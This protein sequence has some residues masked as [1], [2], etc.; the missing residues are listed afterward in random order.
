VRPQAFR[1]H[2]I[3]A[4]LARRS[5]NLCRPI[6]RSWRRLKRYTGKCQFRASSD[7]RGRRARHPAVRG[8]RSRS[9]RCAP[10][11]IG[12]GCGEAEALHR[13][14]AIAIVQSDTVTSLPRRAQRKRSQQPP[15]SRR[16]SYERAKHGSQKWPVISAENH[17]STELGSLSSA[18]RRSVSCVHLRRPGRA[19]A[20]EYQHDRSMPARRPP[21]VD[22]GGAI[23]SSPAHRLRK[24]RSLRRRDSP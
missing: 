9:R 21:L 19:V 23:L 17:S 15:V 7:A 1:R 20:G 16:S 22:T 14:Q 5:A 4:R 6:G 8:L 13:L 11:M 12:T 10:A 18:R 2:V 3:I 24:E